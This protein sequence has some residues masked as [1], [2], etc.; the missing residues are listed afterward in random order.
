[1]PV[2]A[3]VLRAAALASWKARLQPTPPG[4]VDLGLGVP[5]MD[6]RRIREELGWSAAHSAQDALLELVRG[7]RDSAGCRRRARSVHGRA[8]TPARAADRLGRRTPDQRR[9]AIET[10]RR[11]CGFLVLVR[12]EGGDEGVDDPG[13][14]WLPAQRR[15]SAI[16]AAA[17]SRGGTA[18]SRSS[19]RT[20]RRPR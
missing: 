10:R 4:W 3:R 5:I 13:S 12:L 1:V 18:G 14:N 9:A 16:A 17:A 6:T 15:S 11:G 20:R 8:A 7:M 19:R 2:P